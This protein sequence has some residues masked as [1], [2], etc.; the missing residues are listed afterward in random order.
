MSINYSRCTIFASP[1]TFIPSC[2]V[3]RICTE[4]AL[5][6]YFMWLLSAPGLSKILILTHVKR[7][8]K[9]ITCQTQLKTRSGLT[10]IN[11]HSISPSWT[12]VH[13]TNDYSNQTISINQSVIKHL[14]SIYYV[15][16][17]TKG[18]E[19]WAT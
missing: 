4:T 13:V 17:L 10:S 11:W 8:L 3:I 7:Q 6:P 18:G 16:Y 14:V 5:V 15:L 9:D 2:S 12:F 19:K 1:D